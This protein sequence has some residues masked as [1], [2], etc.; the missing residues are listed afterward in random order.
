MNPTLDPRADTLNPTSPHGAV[1]GAPA[2]LLTRGCH[3]SANTGFDIIRISD[4]DVSPNSSRV[5]STPK[6]VEELVGDF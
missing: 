1:A 6:P 5:K 4:V 2:R 3:F